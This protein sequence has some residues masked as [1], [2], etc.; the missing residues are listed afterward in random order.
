MRRQ[1]EVP[2][3]NCPR[4]RGPSCHRRV[5]SRW[6]RSCGAPRKEAV[7]RAHGL[8]ILGRCPSHMH[9][10]AR[11]FRCNH[12]QKASSHKTKNGA[13]CSFVNA[14][15]TFCIQAPNTTGHS[16]RLDDLGI[17]RSWIHKTTNHT[18]TSQTVQKARVHL[19]ES[20]PSGHD[21]MTAH[22]GS[23]DLYT[24]NIKFAFSVW[25]P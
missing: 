7:W 11:K 14:A 4:P 17:W 5:A 6:A 25:R 12:K 20:R 19:L 10:K 22:D 21:S 18:P 15:S 3:L 24:T 23:L 1:L 2:C 9:L 16:G 13:V 8:R